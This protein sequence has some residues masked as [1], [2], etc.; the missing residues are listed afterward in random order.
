MIIDGKNIPDK[1]SIYDPIRYIRIAKGPN[2]GW[3]PMYISLKEFRK[4][5]TKEEVPTVYRPYWECEKIG[6]WCYTDDGW[7]IQCLNK[8]ELVPTFYKERIKLNPESLNNRNAVQC[9]KFAARTCNVYCRK[10]GTLK[11][12]KFYGVEVKLDST[13]LS[14][15]YNPLGKYIT[16]KKKHFITL[17]VT[18]SSPASAYM[19]SHKVSY[20]IA[21]SN[22]YNLL[23]KDERVMKEISR[24]MGTNLIDDLNNKGMNSDYILD[25]LKKMIDNKKTNSNVKQAL[26]LFLLKVQYKMETRTTGLIDHNKITNAEI[27]GDPEENRQKLLN[28]INNKEE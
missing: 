22:A 1:D 7:I 9:F 6:D 3:H 15:N 10:D 14:E 19:I 25:E 18:G 21:K 17:V 27:I 16:E 4:E 24:R 13:R 5:H 28:N 26:L 12:T 11:A 8:Y 2:E 20:G 23:M